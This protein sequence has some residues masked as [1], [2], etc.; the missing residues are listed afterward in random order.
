MKKTIDVT[1]EITLPVTFDITDEAATDE[2]PPYFELS[3]EFDH[4]EALT[5][6]RKGIRKEVEHYQDAI[7]QQL[8][9]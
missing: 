6:V 8:G 3:P 5:A 1:I 7:M 4:R 9:I 2:M